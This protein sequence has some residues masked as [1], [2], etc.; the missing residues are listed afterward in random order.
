MM[1]LRWQSDQSDLHPRHAATTGTFGGHRQ[2]RSTACLLACKGPFDLV[3]MGYEMPVLGGFD[4]THRLRIQAG[5]RKH[6]SSRWP[7]M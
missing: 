6:Q 5:T 1:V 7:R 4:A 3:L 2:D